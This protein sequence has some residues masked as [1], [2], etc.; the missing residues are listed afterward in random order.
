[1]RKHMIVRLFSLILFIIIPFYS[2][3]SFANQPNSCC[4]GFV[5]ASGNRIVDGAAKPLIIKGVNAEG[6]LMWVGHLFGA[7]FVSES[8]I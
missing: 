7:G 4:Q 6:W 1:M 3:D 5:K 8:K 2:I